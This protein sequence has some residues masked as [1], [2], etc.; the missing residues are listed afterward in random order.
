MKQ[1]CTSSDHRHNKEDHELIIMIS[2]VSEEDVPVML[3]I[4]E[5]ISSMN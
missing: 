2:V 1:V 5:Q 4:Y 3:D